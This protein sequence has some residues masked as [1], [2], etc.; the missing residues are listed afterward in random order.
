MKKLISPI[1]VIASLSV[2]LFFIDGERPRAQVL[3]K[4]QADQEKK[5][6][7]V[8]ILDKDSIRGRVTFNHIKHNSGEYSV[9]GPIACIECHHTAQ[10]K[11]QLSKYPPLA[12]DWPSGRTTTLTT[13]LFMKD[14]N[15]AGVAACRDCHAR[16]G[17]K[18]KLIPEIPILK[19]PGSTMLTKLTNQLA[20]HQVCD[21]CHFQ[22]S[23]N[24][25]NSKVP[26]ATMCVSCHKK[27]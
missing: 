20:F 18:P 10:P 25:A 17:D 13:E 3:A 16:A 14:P 26:N 7:E 23:F 2:G 6:P 15:G 4:P 21:S 1:F 5:M 19:D 9:G 22:I 27:G 12:T 11:A 24:R 8:I